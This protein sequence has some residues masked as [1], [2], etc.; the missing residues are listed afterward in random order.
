MA[1][2]VQ[3]D[4]SSRGYADAR[5]QLPIAAFSVAGLSGMGL[6]PMSE[7]RKARLSREDLRSMLLQE[8]R[9][10]LFEEG[11]GTGS[12]NL[13]FK[14]VFDRL[15]KTRG[16]HLTNASVINRVWKNLIDYQADVLVSIAQ[17]EER[18]EANGTV[19]AIVALLTDLDVS[20]PEARNRA[21]QAVCRIG[22]D[23]NSI[24]IASSVAW[25]LWIR[26]AA[27]ATEGPEEEDEGQ[28]LRAALMDG[29]QYVYSFWSENFS[30]LM[31]V[32]G[33]RV[34]EPWTLAHFTMAVTAYSEGCSLRQQISG[35]IEVMTRPTGSD[36][37]D[38]DWTLFAAGLEGLVNH[39]LEPD[40]EFTP[41]Q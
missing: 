38:E 32:F 30:S 2:A 39:F 41:P 5:L 14:R 20:T 1:S 13:T 37:E 16:V 7:M 21:V 19:Q 31:R 23:A 34:R 26:I 29:Y 22:G 9:E 4:Q 36:G 33:F 28:R 25:P 6:E 24:A 27:I 12:G 35:H 8:G 17:D 18:P 15:E 11:F 3:T 10:V 40:P